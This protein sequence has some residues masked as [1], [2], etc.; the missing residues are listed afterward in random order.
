M[1]GSVATV[2]HAIAASASRTSG[3]PP[4]AVAEASR[5]VAETR[6]VA[7]DQRHDLS[8]LNGPQTT[9][10]QLT[11]QAVQAADGADSRVVFDAT[12]QHARQFQGGS[13]AE[14][15]QAAGAQSTVGA[16]LKGARAWAAYRNVHAQWSGTESLIRVKG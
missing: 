9:E 15:R 5:N 11:A 7:A 8:I 2:S 3:P 12:I 14:V 6:Q 10:I 4:A 13:A 16:N 1:V